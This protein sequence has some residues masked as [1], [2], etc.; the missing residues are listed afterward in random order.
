[1]GEKGLRVATVVMLVL[2]GAAAGGLLE[3][4]QKSLLLSHS[5]QYD[6]L[7]TLHPLVYSAAATVAAALGMDATAVADGL[8]VKDACF[9]GTPT[10]TRL[11]PALTAI[12]LGS[13]ILVRI[14]RTGVIRKVIAVML[15]LAAGPVAAICAGI[16]MGLAVASGAEARSVFLSIEVGA[17]VG[18]AII[19][20]LWWMLKSLTTE[21]D[22][23]Q[24]MT[25]P[26][27][28]LPPRCSPLVW[29]LLGL[30]PIAV[31]ARVVQWQWIYQVFPAGVLMAMTI[32][33]SLRSTL[34]ARLLWIPGLLCLGPQSGACIFMLT[35]LASNDEVTVARK[36]AAV[37]A[38]VAQRLLWRDTH[39]S[40]WV[41]FVFIL[42][43]A[44]TTG[45][46]AAFPYEEFQIPIATDLAF[47]SLWMV[48]FFIGAGMI[49]WH[50]IVSLRRRGRWP[51]LP[52]AFAAG[53]AVFCAVCFAA[54]PSLQ[55]PPAPLWPQAVQ[56]AEN[57]ELIS[58]PETIKDV[59]SRQDL[60]ASWR[61]NRQDIALLFG[62][63][64]E[65]DVLRLNRKSTWF[66]SW[67]YARKSE[68]GHER[69]WMVKILYCPTAR[70]FCFAS[71]SE[72]RGIIER[73]LIGEA[74]GTLELARAESGAAVNIPYIKKK[75]Q[76]GPQSWSSSDY[77]MTCVNGQFLMP[78][79]ARKR[80]WSLAPKTRYVAR[81][82]V[83][84]YPDGTE[85]GKDSSDLMFLQAV[86]PQI[87][88]MLPSRP[89]MEN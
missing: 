49:V 70:G 58:F 11:L 59:Y 54:A 2:M 4:N 38:Q 39:T 80:F 30:V 8:K 21:E 26:V 74:A 25:V 60:G 6:L 37:T 34:A 5:H 53:V 24:E 45:L 77:Y 7:S 72:V 35:V 52:S 62:L 18:C 63:R 15:A 75:F 32:L 89:Q 12:F 3:F 66:G 41:G 27:S 71:S 22:E 47:N 29:V 61:L 68:S 76:N 10:I 87:I 79:Q 55:D 78:E 83:S 85:A 36:A 84:A 40:L 19:P 23:A 69:A 81:I 1:M 64:A 43:A 51:V 17:G 57:F 14:W 28:Q 31:I 33:A 73:E 48:P 56:A 86:L 88:K 44:V 42:L 50:C 20:G 46:W 9:T 82:L 67:V 16:A 65:D 13:L